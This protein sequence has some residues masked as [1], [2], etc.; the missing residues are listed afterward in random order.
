LWWGF[1]EFGASGAVTCDRE[2][3]RQHFY[4]PAA[5][6]CVMADLLP[7]RESGA[8]RCP[9]CRKQSLQHAEATGEVV[10]A[11]CGYKQIITR[12]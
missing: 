3:L 7:K 10:C 1:C 2:V 5:A 6:R 11:N 8:M 9:E 12:T 4:T